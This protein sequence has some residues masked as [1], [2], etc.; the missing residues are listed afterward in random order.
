M[1]LNDFST[2]AIIEGPFLP[3]ILL[4]EIRGLY[5]SGKYITVIAPS[6]QNPELWYAYLFE[7]GSA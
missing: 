7:I 1:D 3:E 6:D 2:A 5:M 4:G